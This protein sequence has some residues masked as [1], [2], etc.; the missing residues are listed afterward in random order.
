MMSLLPFSHPTAVIGSE[1][2]K[3]ESITPF[4]IALV[5]S[6]LYLKIQQHVME[7]AKMKTGLLVTLIALIASGNAV[8]QSAS[9]NNGPVYANYSEFQAG[10]LS[11][12]EY[13][14]YLFEC[15]RNTSVGAVAMVVV[16]TH[17]N[18]ASNAVE[19]VLASYCQTNGSYRTPQK[20]YLTFTN[21]MDPEMSSLFAAAVSGE[22]RISLAF[23]RDGNWDSNYGNNYKLN[24]E[25]Q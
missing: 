3:K 1:N 4:S 13:N 25:R 5:H 6:P 15:V 23:Y 19:R 20:A 16:I 17:S 21:E 22:I 7:F 10:A 12:I 14:G 9:V 2:G 24:F 8:G 18:G 11:Q